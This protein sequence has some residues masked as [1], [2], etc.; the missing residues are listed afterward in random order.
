MEAPGGFFGETIT[1]IQFPEQQATGIRGYPATLEIGNDL[2]G[3]NTFTGKLFMTDCIQ[4]VSRLK[5]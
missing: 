3:E 5:S 1:L 2:L 4:R